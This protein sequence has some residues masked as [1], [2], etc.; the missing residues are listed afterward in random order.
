MN[1]SAAMGQPASPSTA[2]APA[3]AHDLPPAPT[4]R[5][6]TPAWQDFEEDPPAPALLWPV[7]WAGVA[8]LVWALI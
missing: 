2:A 7:F 5:R 4:V 8:L 1:R 3:G 6:I